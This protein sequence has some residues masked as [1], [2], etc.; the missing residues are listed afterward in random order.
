MKFHPVPALV[1]CS[2]QSGISTREQN[3]E[4]GSVAP[5]ESGDSETR[6]YG[7]R[8][9]TK[10]E[11]LHRKFLSNALDRNFGLFFVRMGQNHYEFLAP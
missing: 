7:D 1:F 8:C 5:A 6:R 11:P 2:I 9:V 10:S 4:G 3:S